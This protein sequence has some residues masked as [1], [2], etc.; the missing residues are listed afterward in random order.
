MKDYEEINKEIIKINSMCKSSK[1]RKRGLIN[2]IGTIAK[3]LFGTMD[4]NDEKLINKQLTLLHNTQQMAQHV[5]KNQIK[6]LQQTIAH[7]DNTEQIIQNN[8]NL[9][10]VTKNLREKLLINEKN[11][12]I[13][14]NFI[15]I[16]AIIADLT[17]DTK[18]TSD[19]LVAIK[20]GKLHPRLAPIT[21]II[22]NL[23]KR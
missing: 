22:N 17:H 6:I 21:E 15:V 3:S 18:N 19:Y 16:N 4:A 11:S 8:K 9:A 2:E 1:R 14:E 13:H 5:I 20:Q 7:I 23:K 12:N 10:N